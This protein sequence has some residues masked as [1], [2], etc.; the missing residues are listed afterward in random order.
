MSSRTLRQELPEPACGRRFVRQEGGAVHGQSRMTGVMYCSRTCAKAVAQRR[1]RSRLGAL[2]TPP[3]GCGHLTALWSPA[4]PRHPRG[5][6]HLTP[7]DRR[8]ADTGHAR[9]G[10]IGKFAC[11]RA[12]RVG[13]DDGRALSIEAE[14]ALMAIFVGLDV[15]RAQITY[16]ALDTA[17]HRYRGGADW[18]DSSGQPRNGARVVDAAGGERNGRRG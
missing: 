1:Y 15:H 3:R 5:Y 18:P 14:G 10:H 7:P 6:C 11:R 12:V 13:S 9:N 17:S 8:S 4:M 16:D 2:R